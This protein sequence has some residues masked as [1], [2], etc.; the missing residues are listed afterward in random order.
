MIHAPIFIDGDAALAAFPNKTGG[1]TMLNPYI[2]EDLVINPNN[3]TDGISIAHTSAWLIIQNC[4]ILNVLSDSSGIQEACVKLEA[5]SSI[6]LDNN[7]FKDSSAF[8]IYV[9]SGHTITMSNNIFINCN[10]SIDLIY[11]CDDILIEK[12]IC[13]DIVVALQEKSSVS[14]INNTAAEVYLG[15]YTSGV[16]VS[17]N[18]VM[19]RPGGIDITGHDNLITNNTVQNTLLGIRNEGNGNVITGN[20]IALNDIGINVDGND[21]RIE[22]NSISGNGQYGISFSSID[23]AQNLTV[24]GNVIYNHT[25]AGIR[26]LAIDSAT[27]V[28]NT[29]TRGDRYGIESIDTTGCT[30]ENNTVSNHTTVNIRASYSNGIEISG[31][32]LS[33][34]PSGIYISNSRNANVSGN[35]FHRGGLSL[36]GLQSDLITIMADTSNRVNGRPI[37]LFKNQTGL[38]PGD[39]V[40]AGQVLLVGCSYA[41]ISGLDI[42]NVS[43][44]L[45]LAYSNFNTITNN[46]LSY[47]DIGLVLSGC[48]QNLV[49]DNYFWGNVQYQCSAWGST[50]RFDNGV[51]GNYYGDYREKYPSASNDG[52]TW[53]TPYLVGT[54]INDTH[55]LVWPRGYTGPKITSPADISYPHASTGNNITWTI[56]DTTT[57]TTS[58]VIRRNGTEIDAGTWISG[59]SICMEVDGHPMG[60]FNYTIVVDDGTGANFTDT[61]LVVVV[62]AIPSISALDYLTFTAGE[63]GSSISWT[64]TDLSTN[65]TSYTIQHLY[66]VIDSGTWVSGTPIVLSIEQAGQG[67]HEYTIIVHD[68]L[69][70]EARH[71][72]H[73]TLTPPAPAVDGVSPILIFGLLLLGICIQVLRHEGGVTLSNVRRRSWRPTCDR[74]GR[75]ERYRRYSIDDMRVNPFG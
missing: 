35:Y 15:I 45:Y 30:I 74:T 47:N 2:I 41:T 54:D 56:T 14:I 23:N 40:N 31:N 57:G 64:V 72:I 21:T 10:K 70:G 32:V 3:V 55:P 19:G 66:A 68:G 69:G 24:Q 7:T 39:F 5:C 42:S 37:Y 12:N 29:I 33:D 46:S 65:A 8:G 4:T 73:V 16:I 49:H 9:I 20:T 63:P 71:T 25:R 67:Y 62:N 59:A 18:H 1:G 44:G 53:N 38:Q 13:A 60:S 43:N 22:N 75:S 51:H 6:T 50:N 52:E 17:R 28:N 61:V 58:Y 11:F 34:A 36:S 48:A 26:L 27:I